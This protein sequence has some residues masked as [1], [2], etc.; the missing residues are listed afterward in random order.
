[1]RYYISEVTDKRGIW[2]CGRRIYFEDSL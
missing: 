1:V 2:V